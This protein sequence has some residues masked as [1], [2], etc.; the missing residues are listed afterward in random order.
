MHRKIGAGRTGQGC[1][2]DAMPTTAGL[3]ARHATKGAERVLVHAKPSCTQVPF[4][5]RSRHVQQ[6][7]TARIFVHASAAWVHHRFR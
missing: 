7:G 4:S 2:D 1:Q 5:N 3:H 6:E